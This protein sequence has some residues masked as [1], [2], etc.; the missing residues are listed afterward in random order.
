M[1]HSDRSARLS[2][3][4]NRAFGE[5][6]TFTARRFGIDGDVNKPRVPDASRPEFIVVAAYAAGT[7][8]RYP[9]ARGGK[10]DD[11]A[12]GV[13]VSGP[14]VVVSDQDLP[15]RPVEG[16]LCFRVETGETFAVARPLADGFGR[17]VIYLTAKK[18]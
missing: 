3:A 9:K 8:D 7:K 16:D 4:V 1:A 5:E 18:R 10:T 2:A 11:D 14:R 12:I 13:A 6:F 17:S 15:W